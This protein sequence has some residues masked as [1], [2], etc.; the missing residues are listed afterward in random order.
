MEEAPITLSTPFSQ[1]NM[2]NNFIKPK[3]TKTLNLK[4]DKNNEFEIEFYIFEDNLFFEGTTK[5]FIPQKS[6]KKIYSFKEVLENKYFHICENMNEVYDEIQ[7]LINEKAEQVKLIEKTNLLILSI[8]LITKKIKE[9]IFEIDEVDVKNVNTQINDLYSHII[10]L[11]IE[12]KDLKEK[13]KILEE[14]NKNLE[15]KNK[16]LEEKIEEFDKILLLYKEEIKQKKI[17]EEDLKKIKEWI[18]P[19][20][21]VTLNLVFKKNYKWSYF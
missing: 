8:P 11:L 5:K 16:K 4:S 13:N 12:I 9:C 3:N 20:K 14:K 17:K 18:A 10:Q 7:N 15:E 19:G 1:D 6:Y 2:P 21:K